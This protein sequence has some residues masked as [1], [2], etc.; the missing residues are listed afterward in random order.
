MP[1]TSFFCDTVRD[2]IAQPITDRQGASSFQLGILTEKRS[3]FRIDA[4]GRVKKLGKLP[5]HKFSSNLDQRTLA[6]KCILQ[7][8][9]Y[10]TEAGSF[11]V[12]LTRVLLGKIDLRTALDGIGISEEQEKGHTVGCLILRRLLRILRPLLEGDEFPC[13]SGYLTDCRK[14]A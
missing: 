14:Y 5:S 1:N 12:E 8:G 2:F 9:K 7:T 3:L 13:Q 6:S 10:L 11:L 4:R